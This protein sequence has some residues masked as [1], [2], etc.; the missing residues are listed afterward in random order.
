ML[1]REVGNPDI[2]REQLTALADRVSNRLS[3]QLVP[4]R[5]EHL[6]NISSVTLARRYV[7]GRIH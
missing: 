1:Y 4:P 6:G 3:V 2:M 5:G 7:R